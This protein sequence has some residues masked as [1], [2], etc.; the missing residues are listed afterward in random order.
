MSLRPLDPRR[1]VPGASSPPAKVA[2]PAKID[3]PRLSSLA[4][5]AGLAAQ[6]LRS[7]HDLAV[8]EVIRRAENAFSPDA[9][10]DEAELCIRAELT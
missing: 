8:R 7:E 9:M 1:K 4:A 6:T 10:A 2:K 3:L 5:L